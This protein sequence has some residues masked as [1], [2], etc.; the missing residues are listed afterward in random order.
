[1]LS[2]QDLCLNKITEE[3]LDAP[4]LIQELIVS[5]TKKKMED[6][7]K[8]KLK[9]E[10]ERNKTYI[11]QTTEFLVSEI[12][13]ELVF[14]RTHNYRNVKNFYEIYTELPP[15]CICTA[16]SIAET[17]IR[18]HETRFFNVFQGN[19]P[20][21]WWEQ[22]SATYDPDEDQLSDID[23]PDEEEEMDFFMN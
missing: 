6:N 7:I 22:H 10:H 20:H 2:L 12:L 5:S 4:P 8:L 14:V 3:I 17:I 13:Q 1:M 21:S 18:D 16:T 15:E 19:P 23:Y 11:L 9:E